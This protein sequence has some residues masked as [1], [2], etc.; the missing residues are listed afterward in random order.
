MNFKNSQ[1]VIDPKNLDAQFDNKAK[2]MIND[3]QGKNGSR[4]SDRILS[5]QKK[6]KKRNVS[7]KGIIRRKGNPRRMH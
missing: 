4:S 6:R 5:G 2:D 1:T 3:S 7:Q